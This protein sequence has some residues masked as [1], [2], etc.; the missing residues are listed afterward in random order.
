M[1]NYETI[2]RALG[3]IEGKL[4]GIDV[5]LRAGSVRM[6]KLDTR[7]ADNE[8]RVWKMAGASGVV[9]V[10]LLLAIRAVPWA[11]LVSS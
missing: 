7:V 6:D 10:L 2:H 9:A 8:K 3:R 11:Q 4:D 1:S 5:R